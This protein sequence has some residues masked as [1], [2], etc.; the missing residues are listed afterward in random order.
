MADG[1]KYVPN[2]VWLRCDKGA[3]P[4]KLTILPKTIKLYGQDWAAQY[5]AVPMVNIPAFGAC[6]VTK[7]VCV[8]GTMMWSEVKEDVTLLGQHPTLDTSTCRCSLGGTVKIYFS[9][10]AVDAAGADLEAERQA[11]DNADSALINNVM[12]QIG[13]SLWFP[14]SFEYTTFR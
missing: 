8:P 7:V 1:D 5:E 2:G 9:K 12:F 4:G 10:A 13:V 6:L 3:I 14:T 11:K